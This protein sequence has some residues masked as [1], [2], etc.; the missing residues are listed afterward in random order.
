MR[1]EE[2]LSDDDSEDTRK[3]VV[4]NDDTHLDFFREKMKNFEHNLDHFC[5]FLIG[6]HYDKNK[7]KFYTLWQTLWW[8]FEPQAQPRGEPDGI[9]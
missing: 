1:P 6:G 4:F 7:Y 5:A 9:F 8:M 3:T 2:N